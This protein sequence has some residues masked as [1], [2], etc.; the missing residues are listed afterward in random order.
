MNN[1]KKADGPF[2]SNPVFEAGQKHA[3]RWCREPSDRCKR[4]RIPRFLDLDIARCR[5][6]RRFDANRWPSASRYLVY[7]RAGRQEHRSRL[8]WKSELTNFISVNAQRANHRVIASSIANIN[9]TV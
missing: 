8:Y 3:R 2:A 6:T 4:H 5:S 1:L 9:T 7:K